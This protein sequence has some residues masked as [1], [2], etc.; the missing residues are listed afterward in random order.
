MLGGRAAGDRNGE[1]PEAEDREAERL[2]EEV[3]VASRALVGVAVRSVGALDRD[4][5]L[6][7]FR[8]LVVL[9]TR[10]QQNLRSLA[11]TL[12]VHA[13]T[14]TRLCDRLVTKRLI[15]RGPGADR[16]EV[17]LVLTGEGRRLVDEV[18]ARRREEIGRI[19]DRVPPKERSVIARALHAFAAA[20]G[21]PLDDTEVAFP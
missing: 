5:T 19:L 21:E 14:A 18:N 4:V 3:L 16:R 9:A 6:P 11:A 8:A 13:S 15:E 1:D 7:Q 17:S 12:G 10:G 20:A 2:V